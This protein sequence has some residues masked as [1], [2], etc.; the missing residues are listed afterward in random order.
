MFLR[1]GV[2]ERHLQWAGAGP[3]NTFT[4]NGL[5]EQEWRLTCS[6]MREGLTQGG[7]D[8]TWLG[9]TRVHVWG[10]GGKSS[11]ADFSG[12]ERARGGRHRLAGSAQG[13]LSKEWSMA[14]WGLGMVAG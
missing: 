3:K 5:R 7:R 14:L 2:P 12:Q 6:R 9:T 11:K 13:A 10:L 8:T 1:E 4:R